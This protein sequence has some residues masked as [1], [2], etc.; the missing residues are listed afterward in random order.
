MRLTN[1]L[2]YSLPTTLLVSFL[3]ACGGDGSS[4]EPAKFTTASEPQR[5]RA[6]TAAA[7]AD[8]G[9]AFFVGAF[10]AAAPSESTCPT[11][12]RQG[13]TVTAVFDCDSDGQRIDG[14]IVAENLGDVFGDGGPAADPTKDLVMTFDGYYQHS[15]NAIEEVELDGRVTLKPDQALDIALDATLHG[16]AVF[17]DATLRS[18]GT[19]SRASDGSSVEVDGVGRATIHGAWSADSEN[20]AGALELRGADVLKAN[21]ADA[22]NGCVPITIDGNAAGQICEES[23]G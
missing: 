12:T 7:G 4:A 18:D 10:A 3:A 23:D 8:A 5:A 15:V 13:T 22:A 14:R 9:L 6:L 19:L 11:V 20:P 16:V 2:S 21:F 1:L 17:T